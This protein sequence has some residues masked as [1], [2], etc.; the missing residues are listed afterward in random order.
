MATTSGAA[1]VDADPPKENDPCVR[2]AKRFDDVRED[3][4]ESEHLVNRVDQC[5]TRQ[6]GSDV[7]VDARPVVCAHEGQI[8]S[9]RRDSPSFCHA[10]HCSAFCTSDRVTN[11]IRVRE[12]RKISLD[13]MIPA[14][15]CQIILPS[16]MDALKQ[17][18]NVNWHHKYTCTEYDHI[19][20]WHEFTRIT[21]TCV[22]FAVMSTSDVATTSL[23]CQRQLI[24]VYADGSPTDTAAVGF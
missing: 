24:H 14:G 22:P 18:A 19:T 4:N 23:Q 6:S 3:V 1:P 7:E 12:G 13:D 8:D 5:D 9:Q 17:V 11:Q 16:A 15:T 20:E 2:C 21:F 10:S